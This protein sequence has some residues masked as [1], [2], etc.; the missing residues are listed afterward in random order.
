M[1]NT[2]YRHQNT[3]KGCGVSEEGRVARLQ[4]S[5]LVVSGPPPPSALPLTAFQQSPGDSRAG[6][7]QWR[8]TGPIL[9]LGEVSSEQGHW[10]AQGHTGFLVLSPAHLGLAQQ[11]L[12]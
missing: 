8:T 7:W 3:D 12:E 10:L 2:E 1:F 6:G 4:R 11:R 9:Q 5:G